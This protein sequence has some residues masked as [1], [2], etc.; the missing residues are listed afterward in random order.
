MSVLLSG[1]P[2]RFAGLLPL[3]LLLWAC[4]TKWMVEVSRIQVKTLELVS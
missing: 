4:K 1:S 3:Y 2:D